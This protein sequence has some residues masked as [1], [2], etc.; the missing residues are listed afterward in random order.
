MVGA[1]SLGSP[2][3]I[4]VRLISIGLLLSSLAFANLTGC[5]KQTK[6]RVVHRVSC[7]VCHQPLDEAGEPHG[8]EQAHPF[9]SCV[10]CHGGTARSCDGEITTVDGEP[11]CSGEWL[12]DKDLAHVSPGDGPEYLKNLTSFELDEV[13]PAYLRFVN[14][15]DLRAAYTACGPCHD[16]ITDRVIRS[17]MAHTA[18]EISVA[19]Y[20]AGVQ[21]DSRGIYGAI[22]VTD[23]DY[24][25]NNPCQSESYEL[26]LPPDLEKDEVQNDNLQSLLAKAQ[27][28]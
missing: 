21:E 13:D 12:Y 3:G 24:D 6:E 26:Y 14:P 19:R 9:L 2:W 17:T 8:I 20:R 25:E 27:D 28:Q 11:A 4:L 18:G 23:P 5:L 22:A 15:G 10:D 1:S 16:E 7:L